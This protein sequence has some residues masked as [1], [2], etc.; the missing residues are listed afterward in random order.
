MSCQN[1]LKQIGLALHNY[2]DS[3]NRFPY[4]NIHINDHP[5][6]NWLAHLFPYFEQPFTPR[7]PGPTTTRGT[8]VTPGGNAPSDSFIENN[9]IGNDYLVKVLV[10]P[11]DG[12]KIRDVP[13]ERLAMG[14]YLA[15]NAPN[16]DQRDANNKNT[17]GVFYYWG[18]FASTAQGSPP[19]WEPASTINSITDGTSNTLMVG[20]RPSYPY[21]SAVAAP[22]DWQCG[23][24]VYSEVDSGLGLP[25]T[26]FWCGSQDPNGHSCP[27]GPQWF[28]PGSDKNGCDAH[29]YWSKHSGGGNWAF[30]DG[31]VRFLSYNLSTQIQA[32]LATKAGGE[33][34][35]GY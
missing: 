17:G 24:W 6:S 18:H 28:G 23:A 4:E 1:N 33:P 32:A 34:D 22:S 30:A 27:S 31:S 13:G 25:N 10:C 35:T 11:S 12:A 19:V 20:E 15:V 2:H 26:K 8:T 5:R 9:A 14:N 7:Q 21:L 3:N 29:H 16:T